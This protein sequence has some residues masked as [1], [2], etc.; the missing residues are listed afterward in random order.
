MSTKE[1]ANACRHILEDFPPDFRIYNIC[2]AFSASVREVADLTADVHQSRFGTPLP[3]RVL[4]E[5]PHT[6]ATFE[7][8]SRLQSLWSPAEVSRECMRRE[9]DLL[10]DRMSA[11]PSLLEKGATQK[12]VR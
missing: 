11:I 4:S 8:R 12:E 1:V 6:A 10:Y 3:V 5:I 9:I 2:S 7:A